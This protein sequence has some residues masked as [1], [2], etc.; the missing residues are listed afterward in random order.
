MTRRQIRKNVNKEVDYLIRLVRGLDF[1]ARF[2][3]AWKIIKGVN[4]K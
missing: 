3:I 4:R 2:K 1:K